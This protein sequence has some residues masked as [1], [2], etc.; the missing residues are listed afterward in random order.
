M[1]ETCLQGQSRCQVAME[2]SS[3]VPLECITEE[4]WILHLNS[5]GSVTVCVCFISC[6]HVANDELMD[7]S[8][9]EG[10]GGV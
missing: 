4:R 2:D 1:D 6:S 5:T 8:L 9:E 7:V 10:G 3:I